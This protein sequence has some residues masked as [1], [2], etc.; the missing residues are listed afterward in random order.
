MKG[1]VLDTLNP[2]S[3]IN[4]MVV[5]QTTNHGVFGQ[6]NGAFGLY[7]NNNDSII[8]SSKGYDRIGFRVKADSSC[9]F[10]MDFVLIEKPHEL[11]EVVIRPLKTLQQIKEERAALAMRQ[12]VT[13]NGLEVIQSP[14]TA[15]YQRFSHTEQSKAKVAELQYMDSKT[16]IVKEILRLYV[17]YE[18]I[19]MTEAQF[20]DFI[21]FMALDENFLKTATDMELATFI[22]DKYEHYKM[23]YVPKDNPGN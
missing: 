1:R 8:L 22:K 6:P 15:L 13:V 14:I 9:Q 12:T 20:D 4:L 10:L 16:E 21:T 7:V 17:V 19:D 3:F 2:T 18:V 5:N 23:L 11:E